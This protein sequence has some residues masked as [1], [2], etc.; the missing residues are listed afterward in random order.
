MKR[1]SLF[2]GAGLMLSIVFVLLI[3][4]FSETIEPV[5]LRI[6]STV[7][8]S[9][10]VNREKLAV[11][12]VEWWQPLTVK[13]NE[14]GSVAMTFAPGG[15]DEY[16]RREAE[17]E[18]AIRIA[19]PD[20][21]FY[22]FEEMAETP[23]PRQNIGFKDKL[24]VLKSISET[25][26]E[27]MPAF[28]FIARDNPARVTS[29]TGAPLAAYNACNPVF[30]NVAIESILPNTSNGFDVEVSARAGHRTNGLSNKFGDVCFISETW[31]VTADGSSAILLER[32]VN[33]D[34]EFQF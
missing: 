29:L 3:F 30:W 10:V 12:Q 7:P 9:E 8:G 34:I 26:I 14:N 32:T 31:S 24:G 16:E 18:E 21:A 28:D 33:P 6:E 23:F 17:A 22:V 11:A 19:A 1:N 5:I 25:H 13:V 27:L 4:R 15:L 20:D 2:V